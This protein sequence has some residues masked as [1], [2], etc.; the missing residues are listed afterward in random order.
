MTQ[1]HQPSGLF[2]ELVMNLFYRLYNFTSWPTQNLEAAEDLVQESHAKRPKGLS[3]FQPGT[4]CGAWICR[5]IG[6]TFSVSVPGRN[7]VFA[8]QKDGTLS[9]MRSAAV[10]PSTLG[11]NHRDI[12]EWRWRA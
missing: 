12:G 11:S 3:S 1:E 4:D 6:N 10:F 7:G 2:E 8:I 9:T 5:I